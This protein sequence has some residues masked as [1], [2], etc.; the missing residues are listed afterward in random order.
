MGRRRYP[1]SRSAPRSGP[2]LKTESSTLRKECIDGPTSLLVWCLGDGS[3]PNRRSY[4]LRGFTWLGIWSHPPSPLQFCRL[5]TLHTCRYPLSG[6]TEEL[7][8]LRTSLDYYSVSTGVPSSYRRVPAS[9]RGQ[10]HRLLTYS[11]RPSETRVGRAPWRWYPRRPRR[12][13]TEG[14]VWVQVG[15]RPGTGCRGVRER[16]RGGPGPWTV[17]E[18]DLGNW[19]APGWGVPPVGEWSDAT[20]YGVTY[21]KTVP[22]PRQT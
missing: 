5:P 1:C 9:V 14:D 17:T 10:T 7:P 11:R 16:R 20:G 22:L 2:K 18:T 4:P 13:G 19:T 12:L 21:R 3:S 8:P 15:P 6:P